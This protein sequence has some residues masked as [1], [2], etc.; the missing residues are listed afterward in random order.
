MAAMIESVDVGV[1]RILERLDELRL[2]DETVVILCSDNGG[3]GPATSMSP[4]KGYKGTYYEGGIRVP[5]AVRWPGVIE[6]GSISEVP[7]TGVDLFPTLCS[8]TAAELP[9]DQPLDGV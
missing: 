8:I 9:S 1:G 6:P 2:A 5:L 7:V 3:Y 4:L